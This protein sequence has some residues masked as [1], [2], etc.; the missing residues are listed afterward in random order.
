VQDLLPNR[1][2]QRRGQHH[3]DVAHRGRFDRAPAADA[4]RA[5][6][7]TPILATV[8]RI[9]GGVPTPGAALTHHTQVVDE[10]ANFG[11]T[12]YQTDRGNFA[13]PPANAP[14]LDDHEQPPAKRGSRPRRARAAKTE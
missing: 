2:R 7:G 8:I 4:D 9:A 12:R 10:R 6:P 13:Q 3:P 1:V 5:A 14:A 11:G